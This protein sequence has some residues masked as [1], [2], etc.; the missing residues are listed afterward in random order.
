METIFWYD[1]ETTGINIQ[2]DR[3]LQVAGIR[4]NYALD[5]IEEPFNLYSQL[6][7]DVLP[8][9]RSAL[10][11]GITPE[12]LAEQGV[13]EIEFVRLLR[14]QLIRPNTCIAGFNNLRFDDEMLRYT[15]YRNFYDAYAH[16]WQGNNSRWDLIDSLRCAYALRPEGI[17][18]PENEQG[19]VSL[20]LELL[21]EANGVEHGQ[22]HDALADVYATIAMAKCLKQ[23]QPQL[24][25]YLFALR[26]K[27]AVQQ[28]IKLFQPILHISG[29]FSAA[30]HYL[31]P[32]LPLAWHPANKNAL[33][34][35]DL[36]ADLSP[37]FE[38]TAEQLH[39]DLYTTHQ[40][41]IESGR[42]P[43]PLK[44]LH[45]NRCPVV[46][47]MGV[48]RD[49][50]KQRLNWDDAQWRE[51]YQLLSQQQAFIQQQITQLYAIKP[52]WGQQDADVESQLYSGFFSSRDK[53]LFQQIHEGDGEQINRLYTAFSDQ[54]VPEL[55][56]RFQA[57]NYPEQL[58]DE[59]QA[60]WRRFCMLRLA[61]GEAGAPRSLADLTQEY[62]DLSADEQQQPVVLAWLKYLQ[63]LRDSYQLN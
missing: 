36:H 54:R 9:L 13:K 19:Q 27:A 39:A 41:L 2:A 34:V 47:P 23:Q 37:L 32:V 22:A 10:I 50:D 53:Q 57:R 45:I 7:A 31:A 18:W 51:N 38:S 16:E 28:R 15:F 1:F 29:R 60:S 6:S 59:Q 26:T 44:L 52:D 56:A 25:E 55:L 40:S 14:E 5:I 30:R 17:N 3:P 21:T 8:S 46:A 33:I 61:E 11:T 63:G 62:V 35:C 24:F 49:Q 43:V 20:R 58:T 42:K 48:L 4:T 12:I